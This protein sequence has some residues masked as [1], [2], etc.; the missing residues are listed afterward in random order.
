MSTPLCACPKCQALRDGRRDYERAVKTANTARAQ[1]ADL[2][3][4]RDSLL[5]LSQEAHLE[6]SAD[7]ERHSDRLAEFDAE[8]ERLLAETGGRVRSIRARIALRASRV[9]ALTDME[10]AALDAE[11]ETARLADEQRIS[12]RLSGREWIAREC[13]AARMATLQSGVIRLGLSERKVPLLIEIARA[14][15][16]ADTLLPSQLNGASLHRE[17]TG[18]PST[19]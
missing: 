2:E 18:G 8:S 13:R 1:L 9:P 11:L 17:C 15:E 14:G 7:L 6:A 4:L 10:R 16:R 3:R 12:E 5:K 19:C